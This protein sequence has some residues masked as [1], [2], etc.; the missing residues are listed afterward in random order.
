M[1]LDLRGWK[2]SKTEKEFT[3]LVNEKGHELKIRHS[4]VSPKMRGMLSQLPQAEM[5]H[6]SEGGEA[7][8]TL[9]E[10]IGYPGSGGPIKKAQGGKVEEPKKLDPKKELKKDESPKT[11]EFDGGDA[12]DPNAPQG[13]MMADGGGVSPSPKPKDD[14]AEPDPKKA[15]SAQDSAM[16]PGWA[17]ARRNIKKFTGYA[18]GGK[19]D[20]Q[21]QEPE[22]E[23]QGYERDEDPYKGMDYEEAQMRRQLDDYVTAKRAKVGKYAEGGEVSSEQSNIPILDKPQ[24]SPVVINVSGGGGASSAQPQ[25]PDTGL[26]HHVGQAVRTGI[27]DAL[28]AF[29][30]AGSAVAAPVQSFAQGLA[31]VDPNAPQPQPEA[32]AAPQAP[33]QPPSAPGAQPQQPPQDLYG[34]EAYSKIYEKGL[35]EQ[36]AGIRQQAQG[37]AQLG[38]LQSQALEQQMQT[39]REL[40]SSFQSHYHELQ[41]ERDAFVHDLQ[42]Q[43]IDA[44][45]YLGSMD[46]GGKIATA[47]GLIMG[48]LGS[49]LTGQPSAA[50]TFLN[51]Q[52]DRDINAQRANL[53]KS[54]T[55]L[56]AN[57]R[58]FG[59]MRDATEMTRVMMLDVAKN[60]LAQ[61]AAKTTDKMAQARARQEIGHLE[62]QAA[63]IMSQIAMRKSILGG[64]QNGKVD[65]SQVIRMVVPAERQSEAYKELKEAEALG[66]GRDNV[67]KAIDKVS[68]LNT[69]GNRMMSPIQSGRQI[70]AIVQ[71]IIAELSKATAGRFTEQDSKML[72]SLFPE[73]GDTNESVSVKRAA[74]IKLLNEK[75]NFPLLDS[76]GIHMGA[77][78]GASPIKERPIK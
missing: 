21:E 22:P 7:K 57:M 56:N 17:E 8:K 49:G 63:P 19:V 16:E 65:P 1:K 32:A 45:H 5:P 11:V 3:H 72:E 46:T 43:H 4:S 42:N 64:M 14:V 24:Q 31:G 39:E 68:Q 35:G 38:H 55:L 40:S 50:L 15:K 9:G 41:S 36:E 52:I 78:Q 27:A 54:E 12:E 58:Q 73:A 34:T 70:K 66:K 13:R 2:K 51:N 61:A 10:M 25:Q 76:Y 60:Q 77:Q 47:L 48:G 67:I 75:M 59:N 28:G 71:P 30:T 6:L 37:E 23:K 69:V 62:Q 29:K 20:K 74:A 44:N 18:E 26:A 53:G 33:Q